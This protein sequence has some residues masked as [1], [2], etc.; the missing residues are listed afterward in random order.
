M[1][2]ASPCLPLLFNFLFYNSAWEY[3]AN[4][5]FFTHKMQI[6]A[7]SSASILQWDFLFLLLHRWRWRSLFFLLHTKEQ[8]RS[9]MALS[10]DLSVCSGSSPALLSVLSYNNISQDMQTHFSQQYQHSCSFPP[11]FT[12]YSFIQQHTTRQSYTKKSSTSI[13]ALFLPFSQLIFLHSSMPQDS[14]TQSNPVRYHFCCLCLV[15]CG[16]TRN[17]V[18]VL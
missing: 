4:L 12:I 13:H 18:Y 11:L 6:S 7:Q 15:S 8:P 9:H 16:S 14:R 10:Q 2:S 17:P 3:L 1:L 5:S